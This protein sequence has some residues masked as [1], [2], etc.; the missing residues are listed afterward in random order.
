MKKKENL[1]DPVPATVVQNNLDVFLPLLLKSINLSLSQGVFPNDL[2]HAIVSPIHKSSDSDPEAFSSYRPVSNLPFLS[3]LLEKSALLQIQTHLNQNGLC[4]DFQS[5]YQT[6][7]SC[8]TA[9]CRVVN[10]MQKMV[11]NGKMVVLAQL[12]MSAAFDTVDHKT[13]L[14]LLCHK[15]CISGHVLS[16]LKSYLNGRTFSV[17]VQYVRGGRVLL[18]YAVPQG[19]ILG[20]LLFIL[21]ISD[22]PKL[23]VDFDVLSHGYADDSQLYMSFDPFSNFTET[24]IKLQHCICKIEEWMNNNYL[25]LNVDKT[26]VMFIGKKQDHNIHQLQITI[27]NDEFHTVYKSSVSDSVKFLVTHIDATLSMRKMVSECVKS[28]SFSLKKIKTIKYVLNT[29]DKLLLLKAFVLSK[30]DYNNILLCNLSTNQLKPLQMVLNQGIRFAY[31]LKKR[32]SVIPY[33]KTAHILPVSFRIMYKCCVMVYKVLDGA[34]PHYLQNIVEIQPPSYRFLRSSND[35]L[36]L[37]NSAVT[38]C[39]QNSMVKNWNALPLNIRISDSIKLFKKNLKTY[40]FRL[41]FN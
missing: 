1:Y 24:S 29:A 28:C 6:G 3:K 7:H 8:E 14:N 2:K 34:A 36:K 11:A 18:I 25:K 40:Y 41:A 12:D 5:A 16:W 19:S 10:D 26:E 33:L 39:L 38:N 21:Y 37:S 9:V 31:S 23:A 27:D 13:L 20:P 17:K 4:P 30:M 32:D 22:I 15:F 35:W